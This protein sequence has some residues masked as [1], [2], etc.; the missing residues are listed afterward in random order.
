MKNDITLLFLF[1]FSLS[2]MPPRQKYNSNAQQ[3]REAVA[4]EFSPSP[5]PLLE[6]DAPAAAAAAADAAAPSPSPSP[7]APPAAAAPV[8]DGAAR[9]FI[10]SPGYRFL[11]N[12]QDLF[13][14]VGVRVVPAF[15]DFEA[16]L[17]VRKGGGVNVFLSCSPF[18]W[19]SSYF[20]RSLTSLFLYSLS[21]Q[22]KRPPVGA[23]VPR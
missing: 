20:P 18:F 21:T 13:N 22:T 6:K 19:F 9:N 14:S 1:L 5:P 10:T 2:A 16:E 12:F 7:P 4:S 17:S 3:Q 15:Q 11:A 23:L 8:V